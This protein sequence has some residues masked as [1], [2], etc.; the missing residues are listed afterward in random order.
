MSDFLKN[1]WGSF[2]P[3]FARGYL[4]DIG[5]PARSSLVLLTDCLSERF[6]SESFRLIDMGCGNAQ[7]LDHFNTT[8]LKM[9]YTGVDFS[10][11]LVEAAKTNH[12]DTAFFIDDLNSLERVNGSYDVA[13]Y[14]H[15]IEL[16][17][18]PEKSLKRASELAKH[19]AIRFYEPPEFETDSVEL[20]YMTVG[21][22]QEVP[23]LRRKM[24]KDFY[25]LILS[26]VG[27]TNVDVYS[28][29]HSSDKV[30][31]ISFD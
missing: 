5:N 21:E 15:V 29:K 3:D 25:R 27:A 13:L 12:S 8:S 4:R 30:H 6:G 24:G 9:E 2:S 26:K 22:N 14:S 19:V 31:V 10:E 11:S 23:F 20:R 1:S 28:D 7:V 17:S 18:D 16:L